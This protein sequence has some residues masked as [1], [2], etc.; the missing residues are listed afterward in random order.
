M[1]LAK[2]GTG[3]GAFEL[4]RT[5]E[6]STP[7][8]GSPRGRGPSGYRRF[9]PKWRTTTHGTVGV[10]VDNREFAAPSR[11]GLGFA[12][13]SRRGLG[14]QW[15]TMTQQRKRFVTTSAACVAARLRTR[16]LRRSVGSGARTVWA[17]SSPSAEHAQGLSRTLKQSVRSPRGVIHSD[18][19]LRPRR[20]M[21]RSTLC[22]E[23]SR[24]AHP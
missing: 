23:P 17:E 20:E 8:E 21:E 16:F 3:T 24:S 5:G 18:G 15:S 2:G 12:T 6:I 9:V 13:P 1:W 7:A 14:F 10:I 22:G 11:R 19:R 4:G